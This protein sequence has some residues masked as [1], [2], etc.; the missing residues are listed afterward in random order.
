MLK[1]NAGPKLISAIFGVLLALFLVEAGFRIAGGLLSLVSHVRSRPDL[2]GRGIYRVL[3]LGESTTQGQWPPR[4]QGELDKANIGIKFEVVDKG[5]GGA[6]TDVILS[7]LDRYLDALKPRLV[8]VMMGIN[9][10]E[11]VWKNP[12]GL[13]STTA[14][15]PLALSDLR[16]NKLATYIVVGLKNRAA[17][18]KCARRIEANPKD[19]EGYIALGDLFHGNK[20]YKKAEKFYEMGIQA[21]PG[22]THAYSVLGNFY[23][24]NHEYEKAEKTFKA[25]IQPRVDNPWL[26]NDLGY[27]YTVMEK[28]FEAEAVFALTIKADPGNSQAYAGLGYLYWKKGDNKKATR[29]Y[30]AGIRT[31]PN[32][33]WNY[34]CL[35]QLYREAGEIEKVEKL[36][37]EMIAAN[38]TMPQGY[39]ELANFYSEMGKPVEGEKILAKG[40]ALIGNVPTM[41]GALSVFY[42]LQGKRDLEKKFGGPSYP[43]P[44]TIRNYRALRDRVLK[45]EARLICMQYPLRDAGALGK[46]LGADNRII[47][48]ENKEDFREAISAQGLQ[49]FFKDMFAGDFGHCTEAGNT[50][51][52]R[53]LSKVIL[54]EIFGIKLPKD[55]NSREIEDSSRPTKDGSGSH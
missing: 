48:V 15:L 11:W 29:M 38:P 30:E 55:V 22:D 26:Y 27:L 42:Y 8:V 44:E 18:W 33:P 2:T 24:E 7:R 16:L 19:P 52:A 40:H 50:L 12:A 6:N 20:E 10:G 25:G 39:I 49:V 37:K 17:R 9:D 13:E 41:A 45:S 32:Q 47:Y 31:N 36:F 46:I 53:N 28:H 4:L 3:C 35:A 21:A 34:I 23:L 1:K 54:R 51:I 43:R 5:I 14:R